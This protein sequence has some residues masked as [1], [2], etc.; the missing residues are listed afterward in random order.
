M[1]DGD[2]GWGVWS[3][4]SDKAYEV[5]HLDELDRFPVDD[6]GLLWR[7][8]PRRLG[9]TAFAAGSGS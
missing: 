9:I 2:W 7:P 6:E 5:V 3:H 8:V 1:F 4:V